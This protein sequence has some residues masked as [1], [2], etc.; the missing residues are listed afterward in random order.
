MGGWELFLISTDVHARF[1]FGDEVGTVRS[2]KVSKV[3]AF[4]LKSFGS[5]G[6]WYWEN[7][8]AV[9]LFPERFTQIRLTVG[10]HRHRL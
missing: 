8:E 1:C 3:K 5:Q 2:Y 9:I 10:V 6:F 4:G 7:M